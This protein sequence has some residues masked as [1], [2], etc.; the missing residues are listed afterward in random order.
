MHDGI[1]GYCLS[2]FCTNSVAKKMYCILLCRGL[3]VDMR[4]SRKHRLI[5]RTS[6]LFADDP[7]LPEP[8]NT[9]TDVSVLVASQLGMP[10]PSREQKSRCSVLFCDKKA[11]TTHELVDQLLAPQNSNVMSTVVSEYFEIVYYIDVWSSKL[12]GFTFCICTLSLKQQQ[13]SCLGRLASLV[14][15]YLALA[16]DHWS[17]FVFVACICLFVCLFFLRLVILW[18]NGYSFHCE[19]CRLDWQ[20]L[21]DWFHAKLV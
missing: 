6:E 15:F 18:Q 12:L 21:T 20:Q 7:E 16:I 4:K 17:G 2:S 3:L 8:A 5:S 14:G 13:W 1:V 10:T 9:T 11:N 19:T